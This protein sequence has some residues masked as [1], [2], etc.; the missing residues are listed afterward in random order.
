MAAVHVFQ[1]AVTTQAGD[2]PT[3]LAIIGGRKRAGPVEHADAHG[4]RH[5]RGQDEGATDGREPATR[6]EPAEARHH[7]HA[8]LDQA[9]PELVA[10]A[11]PRGEDGRPELDEG[12]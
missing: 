7:E 6:P 11:L 2:R 9:H 3:F 8:L 12:L 4:E 5:E 1:F 10:D